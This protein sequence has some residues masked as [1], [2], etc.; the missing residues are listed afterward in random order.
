MDQQPDFT[1][2][3]YETVQ[4][5]GHNY[6]A[7]RSTYLAKSLT[8]Q[9]PVVI[10]LFRFP[11]SARQFAS[12]EK[13]IAREAQIL[14]YLK[15]PA[16]PT[17][18]NG[19]DTPDGYCIVQE[20]KEAQ[21]LATH[22]NFTLAQIQQI[23]IAALEVLVY[24][25]SQTPA[26][27][28]RDIKPENL[29][30]GEDLKFYLVDFGFARVGKTDVALSSV[31]AGTFGFMAPEQLRNSDL[32]EAT[33]L[34]G[35]GMTLI[36]LLTGKR[37]TQIDRLIDEDNQIKFQHLLT[38][39]NP[40]FVRW[41][42]KMTA[43]RLKDRYINAVTALA[44]LNK[45]S[46]LAALSSKK[47]FTNNWWKVAFC[48]LPIPAAIASFMT[49][50]SNRPPENR[51]SNFHPFPTPSLSSLPPPPQ[52]ASFSIT[53]IP[54]T[55]NL[56]KSSSSNACSQ[57]RDL[58]QLTKP[59]ENEANDSVIKLKLNRECRGCNFRGIRMMPRDLQG[60]DLQNA[61]LRGVRL[62]N[63]DLSGANLRGAKLE[64]TNFIQSKL[65]NADFSE[66]TA[67]CATFIQT[68]LQNTKLVK[69]DLTMAEFSQSEMAE[70]DL[71]NANLTAARLSQTDLSRANLNYVNFTSAELSQTT[72]ENA[73]MKGVII[74]DTKMVQTKLPQE[75]S[76]GQVR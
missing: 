15:H 69:A 12:Y 70:T 74:K 53:P 6:G 27:I 43:P 56:V 67:K 35:L 75:S 16:I 34:Y 9:Q 59:E 23:A 49:F 54:P 11:K 60:V 41:L 21:S 37:S 19:F 22:R 51:L 24:L 33:D 65:H 71:S 2:Y 47:S 50:S 63:T 42:E 62:S 45:I 4:A 1:E 52:P 38:N 72:L 30:V 10:K 31:A 13:A 3:G 58:N 28:H 48:L 26:I 32:S 68:K 66:T 64:G 5:L 18:L 57:Y 46:D 39:V 8:S 61:D 40:R 55:T 14:T 7:D 29:L 76:S 17:Y 36:C 20:Y 73:T 44:A 25:Q